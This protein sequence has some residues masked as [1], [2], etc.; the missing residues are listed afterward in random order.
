M[1]DSILELWPELGIFFLSHGGLD[2]E[3]DMESAPIDKH[4]HTYKFLPEVETAVNDIDLQKMRSF[5]QKSKL[6]LPNRF[7][8][9]F[10]RLN[11]NNWIFKF[12]MTEPRST[13]FTDFKF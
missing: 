2:L 7:S 6:H 9:T 11:D 1:V 3:T 5:P 10:A 13:S 8:E 4:I 12:G